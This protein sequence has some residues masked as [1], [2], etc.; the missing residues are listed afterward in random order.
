MK[1]NLIIGSAQIGMKYGYN[2]KKITKKEL[3]LINK[4]LL[5]FKIRSFDTAPSYGNSEKIIGN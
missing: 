4:T 5:K 1:P 2:K 3:L